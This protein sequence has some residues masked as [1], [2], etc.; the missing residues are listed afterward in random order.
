M[1]NTDDNT[2]FSS[3]NSTT[4]PP[5]P[6]QSPPQSPLPPQ[7]HHHH[8]YHH[9][10]HHRHHHHIH[11]HRRQPPACENASSEISAPGW[12]SGLDCRPTAT[13][14]P[15]II[16]IV[17]LSLFSSPFSSGSV[18]RPW[19]RTRE[20]EIVFYFVF[21]ADRRLG[22]PPAN[23]TSHPKSS[24]KKKCG[25]DREEQAARTQRRENQNKRVIITNTPHATP[26]VAACPRIFRPRSTRVRKARAAVVES[27]NPF[28]TTVSER[29]TPPSFPKPASST[30][31]RVEFNYSVLIVPPINRDI[32]LCLV[33]LALAWPSLRRLMRTRLRAC[34]T[35]TSAAVATPPAVA[36]SIS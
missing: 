9:D 7:Y 27:I 10:H 22:R 31:H 11:Y 14:T 6:P 36:K 35:S 8:H 1:N 2:T 5:P 21:F 20:T 18:C 23:H 34:L 28:R 30:Q 13:L 16:R 15:S 32:E 24:K 26:S 19:P 4:P 29:E 33:F 25:T 3:N 12:S 17:S